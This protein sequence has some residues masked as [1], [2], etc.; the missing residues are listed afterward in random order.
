MG[1]RE[2]L[3]P[4]AVGKRRRGMEGGQRREGEEKVGRGGARKLRRRCEEGKK[5]TRRVWKRGGREKGGM[6]EQ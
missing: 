3:P 5:L 6:K 1:K 4:A 2:L